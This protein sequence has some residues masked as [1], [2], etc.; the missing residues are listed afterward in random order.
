MVQIASVKRAARKTG[1][2][3]TLACGTSPDPPRLRA[4]NAIIT[5]TIAYQQAPKATIAPPASIT[6]PLVAGSGSIA[7]TYYLAPGNVSDWG[8]ETDPIDAGSP[9][10]V[11]SEEVVSPVMSVTIWSEDS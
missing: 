6:S 7:A 10:K 5:R 3:R 11:T 9:S 4:S 8:R 2:R 1:A